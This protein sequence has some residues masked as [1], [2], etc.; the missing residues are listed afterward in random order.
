MCGIVAV[1]MFKGAPVDAPRVEAMRDAMLHRGPDDRG[2]YLSGPVAL[3]HRRLSI[4]DLS[5]AGHQPMCNEDESVWLVFNGEIYNYVELADELRARGHRFRS[6]TDSEVI[7]HLWEEMG[8]RCVDRLNGMFAFVIWDAAKQEMFGA[9]DRLGIKP[10]NYYHGADRFIAASEI[11]AILEDPS[12]PRVPDYQGLSDYLLNGFPLGE[13]TCFAGIRQLQPGWALSLKDGA[14]RTWQ[15]WDLKF[16]YD[17]GR[18]LDDT[19]GE[20][21]L[22]LDDAVRIHCRSDAPLGCHLSG[23]LDSSTIVALT[24]RHRERLD[25]FSIRFDGGRYFDESEHAR[26]VARHVGTTHWEAT[27]DSNDLTALIGA[28]AWH[29]DLP[30]PGHTI[31]A[32]Y[33]ASRLAAEH[34]TV[35]MTGHGGDEIFAGYPA[36][37]QAAFGDTSMFDLSA[38]PVRHVP[39]S[40]RLRAALRRY[41]I[42]GTVRRLLRRTAPERPLD[43]HQLWLK[44]HCGLPPAENPV[45][46]PGFRKQ[47][48]GY[49][50]RVPYLAPLDAAAT[51][52]VLDRCLYHDL[53]A[54]LPGLLH[55][56]DRA[57]MANSIESRVP[58]LDQRV[59][60]F[61]A[62]VPPEQKVAGREPKTL[63]RR[64]GRPL[65]PAEIVNRRDKGGFGVPSGQWFDGPMRPFVQQLI[66]SPRAVERGIFDPRE[67]RAPTA[68]GATIWS[69][70]SIELW[71]RIFFDRD[72]EWLQRIHE[73]RTAAPERLSTA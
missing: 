2:L 18:S 50:S 57:S 31:F 8:P 54:Y 30:M 5:P 28:L 68:D 11:K 41:G 46:L 73:A 22:L 39:A 37:F 36:Q 53:R 62:T 64:V 61:L 1:Q 13:K 26:A 71:F 58:L 17:Y 44:L 38:R 72:P 43:L 32:Y 60:E 69:A 9:R 14:L 66:T 6:T 47:L 12:V 49:D 23:G 40:A 24:A 70:L 29:T 35:S 65:L 51:D 10:F 4:L 45:L 59:V 3:G 7:L 67:L 20:L 33:A 27:P 48:G 15:Y 25:T 56:E 16:A 52:V 34:V 42:G 19:V 55:Q 21:G 63:L